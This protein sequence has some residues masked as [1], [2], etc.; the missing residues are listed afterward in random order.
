MAFKPTTSSLFFLPTPYNFRTLWL[1]PCSVPS[2]FFCLVPFAHCPMPLPFGHLFVCLVTCPAPL[3]I[4]LGFYALCWIP[5]CLPLTFCPTFPLGFL[6]CYGPAPFY[7]CSLQPSPSLWVMPVSVCLPPCL[8]CPPCNLTPPCLCLPPHAFPVPWTVP[9]WYVDHLVQ[10]WPFWVWFYTCL[11]PMPSRAMD[12]YHLPYTPYHAFAFGGQEDRTG[13]TGLGSYACLVAICV[14]HPYCGY[15][16]RPRICVVVCALLLRAC[17]H[18]YAFYHDTPY[19]VPLCAVL[20]CLWI[21]VC[22]VIPWCANPTFYLCRCTPM[23][24]CGTWQVILCLAVTHFPHY[25]TY[26]DLGWL[27]FCQC[28]VPLDYYIFLIPPLP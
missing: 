10:P 12:P 17:P 16:A 14:S 1:L 9:S 8:A 26:T 22:F 2:P 5:P 21:G 20:Y 6:P 13:G 7:C 27:G 19:I 18:L 28:L 15:P 24:C 23:P 4:A 3:P 25:P 11:L